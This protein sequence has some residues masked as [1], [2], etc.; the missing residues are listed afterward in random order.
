MKELNRNLNNTLNKATNK[1]PFHMLHGYSPRFKDE[2]LGKQ[3]DESAEKLSDP[4]ET[5]TSTR[6]LIENVQKKDAYN[7]KKCGTTTYKS[8]QAVVRKRTPIPTG[9]PIKTEPKY[10]GPFIT[11]VLPGDTYRVTQLGEKSKEHSY[12]TSCKKAWPN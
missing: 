12:S 11:D 7:K 2:I 6:E 5:Q 9:Q 10:R 3:A 8:G 4:A 1:N